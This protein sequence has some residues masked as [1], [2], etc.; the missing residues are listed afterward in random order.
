MPDEATSSG[1]WSA[2]IAA[3]GTVGGIG[4]AFIRRPSSD[5][6]AARA[7]SLDRT[8]QQIIEGLR[9]DLKDARQQCA[10]TDRR[11]RHMDEI[12]HVLW[13]IVVNLVQ[14]GGTIRNLP[15]ELVR[16]LPEGA[17]RLP[18]LEEIP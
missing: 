12:A 6:S 17:T 11:M 15:N 8:Q 7:V 2:V 5:G 18:F 9:A 16:L 14:G 3:I 1:L 4:V 10:L 13:H